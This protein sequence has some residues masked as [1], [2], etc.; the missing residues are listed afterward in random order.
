MLVSESV[1]SLSRNQSVKFIP[2]QLCRNFRQLT[3]YYQDESL[4]G[5]EIKGDL[6]L[7]DLGIAFAE[8]FLKGFGEFRQEPFIQFLLVR[9]ILLSL[10]TLE[11]DDK[12]SEVHPYLAV[13]RSPF[14]PRAFCSF[15]AISARQ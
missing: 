5:G 1:S 15:Q 8:I 11:P 14:V 13:G 12:I 4:C 3:I 10:P 7:A 2:C 6:S 9:M